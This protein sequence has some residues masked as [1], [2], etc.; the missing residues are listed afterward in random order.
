MYD[1]EYHRAGTVDDTLKLRK[2]LDEVY[3]LA[4]GMS[5]L[6]MMKLRF[7]KTDHIV[8]LR[9]LDELRA[10]SVEYETVSIGAMTR[11]A[12]VAD[13]VEVRAAIPALA[14]LA[15]GIGDPMVR[16]RGTMGGSIANADPA[17]CY[18]AAC[19]A[20]GA[21]INTTG[22]DIEADD[23]FQGVFE[24]ALGE[25]EL[26][27]GAQFPVPD[28]AAYTK[29]RHP[30]SRFALAGVFVAR[31]GEFVRVGVT[32]AGQS[33]AYRWVEAE[34]ALTE[35]FSVK[36]FD[37]L[38]ADASEM[39]SDIHGDREYRAHLVEVMTRRAVLEIQAG[40]VEPD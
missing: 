2:S 26:V 13:S 10:I 3:F 35:E 28:S 29:F 11:H 31:F 9:D 24:T 7:A 12:D 37:G 17:A 38:K 4:G 6:P 22:G 20:L 39:N 34:K 27:T 32:G 23:F 30:A 25:G 40:M 36:A 33:G 19:I 21:T 16:A 5:L 1:F 8:D 18:P 14:A 15:G